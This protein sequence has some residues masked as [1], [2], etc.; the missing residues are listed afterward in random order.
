MLTAQIN[1]FI[2]LNDF[3]FPP[4]KKKK[5]VSGKDVMCMITHDD[6]IRNLFP[7]AESYVVPLFRWVRFFLK[8]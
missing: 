2:V 6:L 3:F 7:I 5:K 1:H 4:T 8:I